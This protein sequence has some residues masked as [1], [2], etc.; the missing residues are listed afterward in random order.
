MEQK[1]E[2]P[3]FC[4]H[5]GAELPQNNRFCTQC[6]SPIAARSLQ[7]ENEMVKKGSWI[8]GTKIY[9][10]GGSPH[11]EHQVGHRVKAEATGIALSWI[12]GFGIIGSFIGG[13]VAFLLRPSTEGYQPPWWVVITRGRYLEGVEKFTWKGVPEAS[14]NYMIAGAIIGALIGTILAYA[15]RKKA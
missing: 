6:G 5:C 9:M 13:Y 15:V 3:V 12:V 10:P 14:F 1:S 7:E 2:L 11:G 8:L 4:P